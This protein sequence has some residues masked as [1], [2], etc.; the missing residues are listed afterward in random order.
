MVVEL[1]V[2]MALFVIGRARANDEALDTAI[3]DLEVVETGSGLKLV[4]VSGPDG[5]ITAYDLRDGLVPTKQGQVF[6]S[7][8]QVTG[9]G[10]DVEVV[11]SGGTT[12]IQ[13][14]GIDSNSIRSFTLSDQGQFANG[15][16]LN[17]P[18][19]GGPAAVFERTDGGSVLLAD[20]NGNGFYVYTA[21]D[22]GPLNNQRFIEDTANTHVRSVV[23]IETARV[24]GN[25]IAIVASASEN[26][27]TSYVVNGNSAA[28]ADKEGPADG[29]GIM[30]PT[31]VEIV[32]L[33]GKT[34]VIVASEPN[35]GQGG[36]LS[37]LQ[38]SS[39][40]SLEPVD[41]ITDTGL[42]RFG[43]VQ[44]IAILE[45][46]SQVYVAAGGGD[47][48]ISLLKLLPDGKLVLIDSFD[49]TADHPLDDISALEIAVVGDVIQLFA[50][51]EDR[52]G[53][54]VLGY[55]ISNL[56]SDIVGSESGE[57][58]TGTNKDDII[59]DGGGSDTLRGNN[60]AD[61]FLFES[62]GET[63][64]VQDF[65][66]NED[67]LDLSSIP[68]LFDVNDLEITPTSDGATIQFR[69][70]TIV[71]RSH[72]GQPLTADAVRAAVDIG[73]NR[74]VFIPTTTEEIR[75]TNDDNMLVGDFR[76]D[77]ISGFDGEDTL[78]GEEGDDIIYSGNGNDLANGDGGSDT[79]IGG[80]GHDTLNGGTDND[81]LDGGPGKDSLSGG[82]GKDTL[83]GG[84]GADT[85]IGG[86]GSDDLTGDDGDDRL[87]G[88][89][90]IDT[91][92]G[93]DGQDVLFGN[94]GNDE[95]MGETGDDHLLGGLGNDLLLGGSGSDTLLGDAGNDTLNGGDGQD[96]LH[97]MDG[98]DF[99]VGGEDHDR[100]TGGKNQDT[101]YGN[102]GDDSLF[103]NAGDDRL[104]G[105]QG[106][107]RLLGSAGR[108]TLDGGD[109]DD[110]I[111][112]GESADLIYGQADNDSLVGD[113]G[114]D[115]IYG[116]TGQDTLRGNTGND[117]L[118][119][120]DDADDLFGG[121]G[122]DSLLGG[123]GADSLE[124]AAGRDTLRGGGQND[125]L[126]GG[127][128]NDLLDGGNGNDTLFGG[129]GDDTLSG[130][131]GLDTLNGGTGND[132]LRGGG[133]ADFLRGWIGNDTL[134]GDNGN[135]RLF[136]EA[137][138]DSLI[139]GQGND[140]A[141]GGDGRDTVRGGAG[142]DTLIGKNGDD[143]IIGGINRDSLLGGFGD[144]VLEG[145][146]GRDTLLGEDGRDSLFGQDGN[147]SLR[148]M[149]EDDTLNGGSGDDTLQGGQ[150]ND[151]LSGETG[152][153]RLTGG[154][155]AD[156]LEGGSGN[157]RIEGGDGNDN[158]TGGNGGDTF[159]FW[160][161]DDRDLIKDFDGEEDRLLLD[162]RL[163]EPGMTT[164]EFLDKN[165]S[166]SN[167][168]LILRLGDGD[169]I[170]FED[171]T[172]LDQLED[173]IS[174]I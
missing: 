45:H 89:G 162:S 151:R 136:G 125:V 150:G 66:P 93:G 139:G 172:N 63:D 168:D 39:N 1:V 100:L 16:N 8:D 127:D 2:S 32:E 92:N 35:N 49:G 53:I 69:E 116:G 166:I 132:L 12:Y 11:A 27:V 129:S 67:R 119:G 131:F 80:G 56:G 141:N 5:G 20:P 50:A 9:G 60:G 54:T 140:F 86:D 157:D 106:N 77:T 105:S 109:G 17:G 21:N 117:K 38:V 65:N 47:F 163:L 71:L 156:R 82:T 59:Y 167:G 94:A 138:N 108:D 146:A 110:A 124:G 25:D 62:D 142:N 126:S 96:T 83:I 111:F 68:F 170:T 15:V 145:G 113:E 34:F 51:S 26:G 13:I 64:Y 79:I 128:S 44:N 31:D 107:D 74:S 90:G 174:F 37:V 43:N 122:N 46:D 18:S 101:L 155:G 41:H 104:F 10:Y 85:L 81:L 169:R 52:D 154:N 130:S 55:D 114:Y 75:G 87:E 88:K 70:E 148:G 84:S 135:D 165:G 99:L 143:L 19:I 97:G 36:A 58:L 173:A 33:D 30:K 91:L 78:V 134:Y 102:K 133:D 29:F 3:S 14:S 161:G 158:L 98:N 76:N 72:D 4:A 153:D 95:I 152:N 115:T 22:N 103:G 144:D 40:G 42:S 61:R 164:E 48:G 118:F 120:K 73:V 24:G 57:S 6:H 160:Q 159:V 7:T 28:F 149:A 123:L 23:D 121:D 137:G 147:D 171:F 112:G